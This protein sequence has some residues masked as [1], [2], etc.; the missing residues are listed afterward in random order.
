MAHCGLL[1][2]PIEYCDMQM[3]IIDQWIVA[4]TPTGLTPTTGCSDPHIIISLKKVG[5]HRCVHFNLV[6]W[7]P[8]VASGSSQACASYNAHSF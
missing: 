1:P 8:T 3:G 6:K 7:R 5:G 2:L 4:I